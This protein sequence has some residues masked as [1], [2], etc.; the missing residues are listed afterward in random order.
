MTIHATPGRRGLYD[1]RFE[2]DS[3]GVSFVA[4]LKGVASNDLVRTGLLALTNLEHRGATGAEPDTGDG[5]GILIQIP[6]RLLR[7]VTEFELPE[8]GSYAAGM[9]FLPADGPT[10]DRCRA[11]IERIM[12]E[13][14]LE[15]LGWRQVPVDP[16]GLGATARAAMPRFEQLFV[17]APDR[18]RGIALDRLTFI[19]RKRTEH[20]LTGDLACYFP[21][22]SARTIVYKGMLTTPQLGR[23]FTDLTDERI[24]SALLLVH[25]RFST[26][27]FPSWPLA[28]P[29]RFVAHNGEINTVQGNQ[30][31]MRAREALEASPNL[32]GLERAFPICTP[33][34]SDTA[35]FDEVLELLHLAGRPLHHAVLMMIPE[36]WESNDVMDPARRAF[37]RYHAS[38]M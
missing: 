38:L 13:E 32:P 6:D 3:C 15:V 25:S 37:Y 28:H 26:N 10:A 4:H 19:A 33:G 22:L 30:N 17:A 27:T 20:E 9:C 11:E 16:S 31:W 18:R 21:S 2:H 8:K 14:G 5:A 35:R 23:F 1:P 7:G 24:E 34:G 12:L 29:Y 36:A